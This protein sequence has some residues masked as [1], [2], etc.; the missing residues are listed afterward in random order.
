MYIV[1]FLMLGSL[2]THIDIK[3]VSYMASEA[4]SGFGKWEG[5]SCFDQD[6]RELHSLFLQNAFGICKNI[7]FF[8]AGCRDRAGSRVQGKAI[9]VRVNEEELL[10]RYLIVGDILQ[11]MRQYHVVEMRQWCNAL[12][13]LLSN[14]VHIVSS[15][16]M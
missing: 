1:R 7:Q 10:V 8:S 5:N 4:D 2:H 3:N 14:P 6:L 15:V 11:N 13:S 9:A 16:L 12:V